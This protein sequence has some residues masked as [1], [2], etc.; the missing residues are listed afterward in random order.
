MNRGNMVFLGV[1]VLVLV[2]VMLWRGG[3]GGAATPE[4]FA[5]KLTLAAAQERAQQSGKPVLAFFTAD[6][7]P[8]CQQMKRSTLVESSVVSMIRES[9]I[10]VYVD[11]TRA[12]RGD[13]EADRLLAQ[14]GI[15]AFP[16]LLLLRGEEQA[17]RAEG[18]L[19]P[20]DF[21]RWLAEGLART[22]R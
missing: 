6:W 10:P 16:T 14:Y 22:P 19:R 12:G 9:A 7:C 13:A 1:V 11:A 18:L 8:P 17:A 15:Q 3:G 20:D 4:V 5:E 21:K 2:G